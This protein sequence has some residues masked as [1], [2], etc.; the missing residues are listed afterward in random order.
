MAFL[1]ISYIPH[2]AL[3]VRKKDKAIVYSSLAALGVA[4]LANFMLVPLYGL[5]GAAW[6]AMASMATM[7]LF[8]LIMAIRLDSTKTEETKPANQ[9]VSF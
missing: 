3:F 5:E 6:A 7:F 4:A 2:Y 9:T 1:T 8:K